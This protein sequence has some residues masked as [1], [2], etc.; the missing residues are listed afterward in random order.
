MLELLNVRRRGPSGSVLDGAVLA[1][2]PGEPVAIVGVSAEARQVLGRLLTGSLRPDAGM[3]RLGGRGVSGLRNQRGGRA[4]VLV[5]APWIKATSKTV[6]Q[7]LLGAGARKDAIAGLCELA[8]LGGVAEAVVRTLP[9]AAQVR[10][11]VAAACAG[12][13]DLLVV[14]GPAAITAPD[15]RAALL[16]D[17]A[18]LLQSLDGVVVWLASDPDEA[19]ALERRTAVLHGGVFV[20]DGPAADVAAHPRTLAAAR[21]VSSPALNMLAVTMEGATARLGDGA[22]LTPP[23]ALGLPSTGACTLAFRPQAVA[24]ERQ[25]PGAL[26]FVL[27]AHGPAQAGE[28]RY[29]SAVFAG[30][31]WLMPAPDAPPRTG[32]LFN[33]FVDPAAIMAFDETGLALP[34]RAP[35]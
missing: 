22:T 2:Q 19:L 12:K 25:H 35:A 17:I 6:R 31:E 27:R 16:A 1:V 11:A 5:A 20:Q 28:G 3:V 24:V 21:A 8:G 4:V 26:R 32:F 15:V 29:L 13:P 9:P 10:L 34:G 18:R 23:A 33:A 30:A 14:D 7:V